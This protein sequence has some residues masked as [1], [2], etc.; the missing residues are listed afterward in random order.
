M[1]FLEKLFC[2]LYSNYKY[3]IDHLTHIYEL[4]QLK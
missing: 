1:M 2:V 3:D 4:I